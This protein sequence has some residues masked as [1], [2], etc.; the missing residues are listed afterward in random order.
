MAR[1]VRCANCGKEGH[2]AADCRGPKRERSERVCFNC[3]EPGHE[4][5]NCK[6]PRARAAHALERDVSEGEHGSVPK[7]QHAMM[8]G[9]DDEEPRVVARRL[10]PRGAVRS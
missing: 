1:K 3:N 5:R 7:R 10:P 2:T 6:K 9:K 8:V 4:S